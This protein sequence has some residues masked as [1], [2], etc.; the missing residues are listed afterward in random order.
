MLG[1]SPHLLDL[2][3]NGLDACRETINDDDVGSLANTC[4]HRNCLQQKTAVTWKLRRGRDE[5][6]VLQYCLD[7]GATGMQV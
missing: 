5:R 1:L 3:G 6:W 2:S 4:A 7:V